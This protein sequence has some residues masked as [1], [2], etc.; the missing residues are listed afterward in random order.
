[1]YRI[2]FNSSPLG[3]LTL[4]HNPRNIDT[5]D[6]YFERS[7]TYFGVNQILQDI[8]FTW[9]KE[10]ADYI[11]NIFY[12]YGCKSVVAVQIQYTDNQLDFTNIYFGTLELITFKDL[13]DSVECRLVTGDK[14]SKFLKNIDTEYKVLLP[15]VLNLNARKNEFTGQYSTVLTDTSRT[16]DC[17]TER[18]YT[19]SN[20]GHRAFLFE[21]TKTDGENKK[22][23]NIVQ[24][25]SSYIKDLAASEDYLLIT[26]FS[27][28]INQYQNS[29]LIFTIAQSMQIY[30]AATESGSGNIRLVLSVA[31]FSSNL[32]L[33]NTYDAAV[34]AYF[35]PVS[36]NPAV[37]SYNVDF[38]ATYILPEVL[39]LNDKVIIFI[40]CE[41]T[42]I[43]PTN[44]FSNVNWKFDEVGSLSIKAS[45]YK[46]A[47]TH[48]AISASRAFNRLAYMQMY[49]LHPVIDPSIVSGDIFTTGDYKFMAVTSGS[50]LRK[51]LISN[52]DGK[53]TTSF[54]KLF[55]SLNVPFCLGMGIEKTG[56]SD[57]IRVTVDH[58]SKFFKP[59]IVYNLGE[60][61]DLEIA[62]DEKF[63]YNALNIDYP[64]NDNKNAENGI[65]E[66]VTKYSYTT[67]CRYVDN[68]LENTSDFRADGASIEEA[69]TNEISETTENKADD[70]SNFMLKCYVSGSEFYI[71]NGAEYPAMT[72]TGVQNS[73]Q[74][75]NI[76]CYAPLTLR[77]WSWCILSAMDNESEDIKI[78]RSEGNNTVSFTINGIT[79]DTN[80]IT[81]A[82]LRLIAQQ[83]PFEY[84]EGTLFEPILFNFRKA[85]TADFIE[86]FNANRHGKIAFTYRGTSYEGF[87]MRIPSLPR[88][89]AN[90]ILLKA[91]KRAT[92]YV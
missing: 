85:V 32:T 34:T 13:F 15:S 68:K 49:G 9:I 53:M 46:S 84:A 14:E 23:N 75:V 74:L 81:L 27:P 45:E 12:G 21:A 55:Q 61:N 66:Y 83:Q 65:Y 73:T 71:S 39:S 86:A 30:G 17:F 38:N 43:S 6:S 37:V 67:P 24:N 7:E 5:I 50:E 54:A 3:A 52:V 36:Y 22:F 56:N 82:K 10:A 64:S 90:W 8:S 47:T 44:S 88:T 51:P 18:L 41:H 76:D 79:Y 58:R 2:K 78:Q 70:N 16:S 57:V 4:T 11:R 20:R 77:F 80:D 42:S 40:R 59:E 48:R 69:R 89:D 63:V 91:S 25:T 19:G 29:Q 1:M 72:Y 87:A 26:G 28:Y 35:A 92:L 31:I 60:V 33:K 62:Y